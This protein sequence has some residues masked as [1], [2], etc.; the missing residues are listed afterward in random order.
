MI[1]D[2]KKIERFFIENKT[3][4]LG[5]RGYCHDCGKKHVVNV[6]ASEDGKVSVEGGAVYFTE[7]GTFIKCED[8]FKKDNVLHNYREI[9]VYSRIVGYMRPVDNWNIGKKEEWENR[10]NVKLRAEN[11]G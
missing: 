5:F 1:D 8:C 9:D 4:K 10:R 11:I 3:D 7:S 2:L 6:D